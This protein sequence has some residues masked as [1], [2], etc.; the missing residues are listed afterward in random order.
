MHTQAQARVMEAFRDGSLNLLLAT[1]VGAE[2]LDFG[3]C[4][5]VVLTEPPNDVVQLTQVCVC[6]WGGECVHLCPVITMC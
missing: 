1:H 5:R 6:V 4:N 2:G 3:F